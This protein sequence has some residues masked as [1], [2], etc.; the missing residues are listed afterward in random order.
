MSL[1]FAPEIDG[2]VTWDWR[3]FFWIISDWIIC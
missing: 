1:K 3:T 2:L